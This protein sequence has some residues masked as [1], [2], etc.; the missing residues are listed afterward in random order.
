MDPVNGYSIGEL[1]RLSGLSVRTIRFYSDSGVVPEGGRTSSGY[2][3][4]DVT[5]LARLKLVRTLRELGVDLP[6]VQRVLAREVT[7]ADVARV[8]AEAIDAQM[9]TLRLR[10]AVL[11]AVA[12]REPVEGE[13]EL[14]H[15]LATLSEQERQRILDD[16][17]EEVF[18]GLDLEPA[19]AAMMTSVK[20]ELPED[21]SPEQLRAWV[22]L[23]NLVRDPDFRALIRGLSEEHAAARAAGESMILTEE[24]RAAHAFAV[25]QAAAAMA[26]GVDPRS[27][28]GAEV[29]ER[30]LAR[31]SEAFGRPNDESLRGWL[32]EREEHGGD[33]RAE[34]YWQLLATINGWPAVP[35]TVAERKWLM[36]AI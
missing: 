20:I 10:R 31:W 17:L 25:E 8:H 7:L 15:D 24:V 34:R 35:S 36:E 29:A 21:P 28:E 3:T 6:T 33:P 23:A 5:H 2:R 1:A 13:V 14:M 27:P 9:R 12:K 18:G 19:F 22:E 26:A 16:F 4:Y 30:A 11:R 32:R